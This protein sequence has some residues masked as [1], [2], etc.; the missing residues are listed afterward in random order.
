MLGCFS[1]KF[2]VVYSLHLFCFAC[3]KNIISACCSIF[4]IQKLH[5]VHSWVR[6]MASRLVRP[7]S[8]GHRCEMVGGYSSRAV[9]GL[10][11]NQ[12]SWQSRLVA[13]SH[14]N[15]MRHGWQSTS[16]AHHYI[17]LCILRLVVNRDIVYNIPSSKGSVNLLC[18]DILRPNLWF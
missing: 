17:S 3:C 5:E 7:R 1:N 11:T 6:F 13:F 4:L 14:C 15:D 2:I 10:G 12:L 9:P 18:W 8:N 16:L